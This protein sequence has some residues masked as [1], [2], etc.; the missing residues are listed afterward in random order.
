MSHVRFISGTTHIAPLNKDAWLE[1]KQLNWKNLALHRQYAQQY[2]GEQFQDLSFFTVQNNT[3]LAYILVYKIDQKLCLA[4]NEGLKIFY[5]APLHKKI[6]K[7]IIAHLHDLA[8]IH[9]CHHIIINDPIRS[10]EPSPLGQVLLNENFQTK[11]NFDMQ[12]PCENFEVK[13]YHTQ[14]RKSYKSLINWGKR[15]L[16]LFVV[17]QNNL[18]HTA[19]QSFQA[20]HYKIAQRVTRSSASWQTQFDMIAQGQ[21]YLILGY[22]EAELVSSA[23]FLQ[24]YQYNSYAVGV[25]E[26]SLFQHGISHYLLYEGII[27]NQNRLNL[28]LRLGHFNTHETNEKNHNIQKFKKGFCSTLHPMILWSKKLNL[29]PA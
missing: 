8:N 7:K 13:H 23:L 28:P 15:N 3:I 4:G 6:L 17:D 18:D 5:D 21:G 10:G 27:Q 9:Q 22:L 25:Y 24:Q 2:F 16:T 29:E 1:K 14:I 11:L 12:I 26:R 19:W 20:F